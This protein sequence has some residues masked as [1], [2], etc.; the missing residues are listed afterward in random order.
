MEAAD[1][2]TSDRNEHHRKDWIGLILDTEAIPDFGQV[3]VLDIQHYQNATCHKEQ[4]TGKKRIY[5]SYY[6]ILYFSNFI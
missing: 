2:T 1:G 3:W 6:L 5:F 4:G